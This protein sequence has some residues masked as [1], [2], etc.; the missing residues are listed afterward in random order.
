MHHDERPH[1]RNFDSVRKEAKRWLD[2]LQHH[3]DDA[4]ARLRRIHPHAL[5]TPTLRDVQH[6][7]AMELGYPGWTALK[8]ALL[9]EAQAR[10]ERIEQYDA[11][12]E[13]LLD[14]YRTGTP[15]AMERHWSLTWHRRNWQGMRTYV[16]VDLGKVPG[17]D[18]EITLDDA[19]SLIAREHGFES[20]QALVTYVKT[21]A[22]P[23]AMLARPVRVLGA[24]RGDDPDIVGEGREWP[25]VLHLL[26]SSESAGLE[27][28][29]QMTDAMLNDVTRIS[30]LTALRLGGSKGVTDA[31]LRYLA[32]LPG[33]RHLDLSG[34]SITDGGLAILRELRAL[35][36][37]SL[38]RTRTS[39]V[40]AAE[41]SH[42]HALTEVDLSGTWC[43]DGAMRALAGK[44]HVCVLRTGDATTDAGL[45]LL[46]E[47]P[48]FKRW[49][50]GT[51]QFAL[52]SDTA[53]PNQLVP[54][55]RF[56]SL[57]PM[58]GLDGLFGLDVDAAELGLAGASLAPLVDLPHLGW[59]G[60]DAKD[61]AM[62]WIARLPHLRF[63]GCQDTTATDDGFV[64]LSASRTI[65]QIWGRRCHGL[66]RRGFLALSTMPALR[67]L[68]VSCR[69]VDDAG[70]AAL[71]DFPALR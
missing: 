26:A 62:P 22:S 63:L 65:E 42:A 55:G 51:P 69:N 34:T 24:R 50:G 53:A 70:V 7:L 44:A 48:V 4:L 41:L 64:A 21:M 71:P 8:T 19:R 66:Q 11:M 25:A 14:A 45:A 36:T 40:G 60:F 37:I 1:R 61:D 59:L 38:A 46:H 15:A 2:A 68:S 5:P 3:D 54:R 17:P 39:D 12:V 43:G 57:E 9:T 67:G 16:Q 33:L 32:R 28:H 20:W 56:S 49:Q 6:A 31:G 30:H 47:L 29:G 58:R 10:S 52:L 35:E 23:A 13:A 27:A 18:V